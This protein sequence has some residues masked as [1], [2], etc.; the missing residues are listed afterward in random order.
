[1]RFLLLILLGF[2]SVSLNAQTTVKGTVI[3]KGLNEGLPFATVQFTG[4]GIGTTTDVNGKFSITTD[5]E[6]LKS[7]T[8]SFLGFE[9]VEMPIVSG[10]SQTVEVALSEGASTLDEVKITAKRKV[11]KDPAAIALYKRVVAAKERISPEN[12]DYYSYE[13]YTKTEFDLYNVKEK[14]TK[15]KILNPIN[16]VFENIDTTADGVVYL[17]LL[18]K[19]KITDVYYRKKPKKTKTVVK[20]DQFSGVKDPSISGKVEY[21]FPKIDIYQ[22]NIELGGKVFTSPFARNAQIIYKYFLTDSTTVGDHYCYKLEFTPRRKGDLAFTGHAWIDKESA[23]IKEVD[24]YVLD[25]INM[26]FLTGMKVQQRYINLAEGQWFKNYEQMEVALNLTESKKHQAVRVLQTTSIRDIEVNTDYDPESFSGD[27]L[28]FIDNYNKQNDE[29]WT[30]MRH[31]QL[32]ETERNIYTLIDRVKDTKMYKA[33]EY[34]GRTFSSGFFNAGPVEFGRFYQAFSW[35]AIEG[36]RFRFGMRTNPRQFRDKFLLEGYVAYGTKDKLIKYHAGAKFHLKRPNNKWHMVGGHYHYDWSD[37]NFKNPYMSHDHIL[38][39][40]LRKSPLDNLF[41]IREGYLFYDKEWIRGL[42][43]KLSGKHK[44]VYQ[45]PNSFQFHD[46]LQEATEQG[47]DHFEAVEIGLNTRWAVG[48]VFRNRSGGFEKESVDI[49]KPVINVNYTVGINKLLGS[50]YGYHKLTASFSQRISSKAGRTYYTLGAHKTWGKIPYPLLTIHKGNR[51]FMWNK[52]AYNMMDDLEFVN[53][54]YVNG[55]FFHYFDGFIFNMIPLVNKLKLRSVVFIKGIYGG[56]SEDNAEL[57]GS[58]VNLKDLN[59]FYSEAG[60][61]IENIGKIAHV[62]FMWRL[63]QRN[64]PNVP[65]FGFRFDI[66]PSF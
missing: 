53:D 52:H 42:T 56:L 40:L 35:N 58:D 25:K 33:G 48:E 17:P 45:W 9:A 41:L 29:F 11:K 28:V 1:M 16:F 31:T 4:T 61:G 57:L 18:L 64:D 63:T 34:L 19:E 66:Y 22:N 50:D 37:F 23:A 59:G 27:D 55:E 3:E 39:S 65:K 13:D 20:A 6:S 5:D 43:T 62:Y 60:F 12:Y 30:K 32:N 21:S 36:N 15:R 46:D 10:I 54:A 44:T 26:N 14:L 7:I 47:E 38:G 24:V 8:V 49:Q 51:N 2:T